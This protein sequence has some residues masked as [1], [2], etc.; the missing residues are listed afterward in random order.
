MT[1]IV[2]LACAGL[3]YLLQLLLYKSVW[4]RGLEAELDL[5]ED[6]YLFEG[7]SITVTETLI[8]DKWLPLPWVYFKY[9]L[10]G[11]GKPL[12]YQSDMFSIANRRRIR[13]KRPFRLSERGVY[14]VDEVN[15]V[16]HDLFLTRTFA[17]NLP[18][19]P[20]TVTVYPRLLSADEFPL[21]P[22]QLSGDIIARRL[23]PEDPF[24]FKGIRDYEPGDS[25]K[26]INFSASARSLEWKVNRHETTV[27]EEV[28]L[29]LGMDKSTRYYD[30]VVYE[31]A[32]RIAGT[33]CAFYE[34]EGIPVS[35]YSNGLD[36][37]QGGP[38][39]V[40][41]GCSEE[42]IYTVLASL[43]RLDTEREEGSISNE[44]RKAASSQAT[45]YV[46][47]T[48][49]YRHGVREAYETLREQ[50]PDSLWIMP[51]TVA[52]NRDPYFEPGSWR[53]SLPGFFF[54]VV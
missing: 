7:E 53:D 33:L 14:T 2:I 4:G 10:S 16:S 21:S 36:S 6:R 46:L 54:W 31:Q 24:L 13:R 35:L 8:N 52:E 12:I 17:K 5:G 15:L 44:M 20:G 48:P 49:A 30:P 50:A 40:E 43:A 18:V 1:L 28:C 3:F 26:D 27:S 23:F 51:V 22:Q 34:R 29:F 25:F 45:Q 47:I 37:L 42:H 38:I 9:K 32:L 19:S 39:E 41:P 11:N